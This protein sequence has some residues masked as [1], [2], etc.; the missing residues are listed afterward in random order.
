MYGGQQQR[1]CG[2]DHAGTAVMEMCDSAPSPSDRL[3]GHY[4]A[5]RVST[6]ATD[7]TAKPRV[8]LLKRSFLLLL[9]LSGREHHWTLPHTRYTSLRVSRPR[10]QEATGGGEALVHACIT[11][12]ALG[13]AGV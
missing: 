5:F 6:R 2:G 3:V 1:L 11:F 4:V 8:V 10:G 7:S 13:A 12:S 9:L